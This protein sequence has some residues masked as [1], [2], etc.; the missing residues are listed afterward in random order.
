MYEVEIEQG[1]EIFQ[2]IYCLNT[3]L[4]IAWIFANDARLMEVIENFREGSTQFNANCF[5][6]F[7]SSHTVELRAKCLNN[8]H[9]TF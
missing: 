8:I 2:L 3:F 4:A 7:A 9:I 5:G 1:K 6:K